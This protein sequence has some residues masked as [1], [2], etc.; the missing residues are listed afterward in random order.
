MIHLEEFMSYDDLIQRIM[1]LSIEQKL[2]IA[3]DCYEKLQPIMQKSDPIDN[4][5][6]LFSIILGTAASVDDCNLSIEKSAFISAF[7]A[8]VL[9][10]RMDEADL[11]AFVKTCQD[12]YSNTLKIVKDFTDIL[13]LQL[14]KDLIV[15]LA[16]FFSIDNKITKKEYAFL[17]S[18]TEQ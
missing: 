10:I 2:H 6:G 8:S 3:I 7:Y 4:G 18:L 15:F 12:M 13:D 1:S 17:K 5:K 14:I 16:V 11:N 9:G